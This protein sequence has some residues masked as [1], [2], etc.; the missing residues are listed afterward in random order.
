MLVRPIKWQ[1]GWRGTHDQGTAAVLTYQKGKRN[2]VQDDGA[3]ERALHTHTYTYPEVPGI[4]AKA[5]AKL[6][7]CGA[8]VRRSV[9]LA[10]TRRQE[11]HH[12]RVNG[13]AIFCGFGFVATLKGDVPGEVER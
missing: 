3:H 6:K 12:P 10:P 11:L 2:Q 8:G 4:F 9:C 13:L 7:V 5:A 1:R